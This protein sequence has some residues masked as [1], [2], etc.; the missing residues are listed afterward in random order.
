M[1]NTSAICFDMWGTLCEG[2]GQKQ[3]D[4]LQQILGADSID[5]RT[6]SHG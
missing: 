5:K 6:N 3:W 1:K 2:G 4:E